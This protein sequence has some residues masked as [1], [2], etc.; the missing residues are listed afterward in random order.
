MYLSR[1]RVRADVCAS[2]L[3]AL[4]ADRQGYGLHRLFWG[5]FPEDVKQQR[6]FLFREELAAEQS[7]RPGKGRGEPIYYLLSVRQPLAEHP[8]FEVDTKPYQ[9]QLNNGDRLAFRL[10]VNAV[11][12]RDGKRHDLLLDA[13]YQWLSRQL[14]ELELPTDGDKRTRKRR[15][16]EHAS[17]QQLQQWR[18]QIDG[19]CYAQK[20]EQRLGRT[21]LL[22]WALKTEQ[23]QLLQRWWQRQAE[24]YGFEPLAVAEGLLNLQA[25]R[26]HP[27]PEK[28]RQAGFNALDLSGELRV[29]QPELFFPLLFEGVGPSKAFG[30]GLMMVRRCQEP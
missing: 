14:A 3:P 19:G 10:R 2:Q 5:L 8:L 27:L 21:E 12:R 13:Q 18:Q 9:P 15:L 1:I 29:Q 11:V 6:D 25:Q 17:D 7:H 24:R 26:H 30:C 22:E 28:G 20:L 4:L 23:Q 16:L